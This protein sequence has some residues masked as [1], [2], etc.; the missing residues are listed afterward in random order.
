MWLNSLWIWLSEEC[1]VILE[2]NNFSILLSASKRKKQIQQQNN[3]IT[4][5][6]FSFYLSCLLQQKH[7]LRALQTQSIMLLFLLMFGYESIGILIQYWSAD[8]I[9]AHLHPPRMDFQ[10]SPC[11]SLDTQQSPSLFNPAKRRK[12]IKLQLLKLDIGDM[13]MST[14]T[15]S[16][17]LSL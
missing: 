17:Y 12:S 15:T 9:A 4:S 2:D 8:V 14:T 6:H 16:I 13:R 3:N 11:R 7:L 5:M 10:W 1:K